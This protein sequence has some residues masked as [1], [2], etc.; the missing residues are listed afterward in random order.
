MDLADIWIW[1]VAQRLGADPV[2][3]DFA[4][5]GPW[6]TLELL[7]GFHPLFTARWDA[8]AAT[9]YSTEFD[10]EADGA[11]ARLAI[12]DATGSWD[13]LSS[14]AWRVLQERLAFLEVVVVANEAA[15][16]KVFTEAPRLLDRTKQARTVLLRML[17]GPA[18]TIDR[19]LLPPSAP[20][21]APPVPATTSLRRQ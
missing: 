9:P 14:G 19:R 6:S 7:W 20:G 3:E 18:R 10:A 8:I 16:T 17:L 21:A 2:R 1:Y 4:D 13:G 12:D 5:I 11:L 15:G